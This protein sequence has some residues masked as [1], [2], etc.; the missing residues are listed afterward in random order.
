MT[1]L[2]V[3]LSQKPKEKKSLHGTYTRMLRIVKNIFWRGK[4]N[5]SELYDSLEKLT[6]TIQNRRV[7]LSGH[8]FRDESSPAQQLIHFNMA[9][10][11]TWDG[12]KRMSFIY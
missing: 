4:N 10:F 7:C 9:A 8:V 2:P 11:C 1:G 5:N 3:G 12:K 6:S